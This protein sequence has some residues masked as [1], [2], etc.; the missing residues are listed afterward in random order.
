MR[1]IGT[2]NAWFSFNGR[3][4]TEFDV[5]MLSMPTRPHPAR[6]GEL[7]DIPGRHGKVFQDEGV[8]DRILVTIRVMAAD[9]A[10]IDELWRSAFYISAFDP[11]R[12]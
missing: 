7:L 1:A 3:R 9:N 10:N 6:K 8:Y 4:N 11:K 5:R 2:E 12:S